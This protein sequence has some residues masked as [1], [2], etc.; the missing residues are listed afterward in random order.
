M[1]KKKFFEPEV[2]V[3]ELD[4][5]EIICMSCPGDPGCPTGGGSTETGDNEEW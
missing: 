5:R 3:V 2:K 4:D 1:D